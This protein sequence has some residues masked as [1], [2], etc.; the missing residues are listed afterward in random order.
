MDDEV[1]HEGERKDSSVSGAVFI[2]IGIAHSLLW[3]SKLSYRVLMYGLEVHIA[4]SVLSQISIIT[5][6]NYSQRYQRI[7]QRTQLV[8]QALSLAFCREF[9]LD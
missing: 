1:V 7:Y 8:Y 4:T 5:L 6:L 2:T 9:D 3:S